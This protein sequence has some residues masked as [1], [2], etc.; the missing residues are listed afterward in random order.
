MDNAAT[1]GVAIE[2]STP[3]PAPVAPAVEPTAPP[4][5]PEKV[6][7]TK[8]QHDQLAR[9]AARA[10]SLQSK[11]DRY[12]KLVGKGG[13]HFKPSTPVTPPTSEEIA[14]SAAAEDRKAERGLLAIAADPV[15]RAVLDADPTLRNLLTSNPLAVLPMYAAD[16]LDADD[17]IS[18]VKEALV[19]LQKPATPPATPPET[20]PVT[21]PTGGV[22]PNDTPVNAEVEAARKNPNP[23][24][25]IAGMIGARLKAGKK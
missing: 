2:P 18:L 23:E 6:T 1:P 22:N 9:D 21:P 17:A 16:A 25:A 14:E 8:E 15:Y 4:I 11:A 20:P 10:R 12:D 19:A 5:E 13:S 3:T 7:L 24:R